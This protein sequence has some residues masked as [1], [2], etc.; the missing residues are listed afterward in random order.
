MDVTMGE[1]SCKGQNW[2]PGPLEPIPEVCPRLWEVG[3]EAGGLP[4]TRC[5]AHAPG[6]YW[7]AL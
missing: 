4:Q 3:A 1:V 6:E 2:L 5:H 7:T